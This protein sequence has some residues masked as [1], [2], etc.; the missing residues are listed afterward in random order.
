MLKCQGADVIR[1]VQLQF[2]P[3]S[4]QRIQV[5]GHVNIIW[6]IELPVRI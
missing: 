6:G 2:A 4:C 3:G 1:A 5:T